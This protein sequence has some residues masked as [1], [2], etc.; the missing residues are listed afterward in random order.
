MQRLLT[1]A[2]RRTITDRMT[3]TG[4]AIR[5]VAALAIAAMLAVSLVNP[6]IAVQ[7]STNWLPVPVDIHDGESIR[8]RCGRTYVGTLDLR[9]RRDVSVTTVGDCGPALI[10]PALPV[11]GWR[12]APHD[13]QTWVADWRMA[14]ALLEM[15]GRFL[16]LA[17]HPNSVTHWLAGS[18]ESAGRLRAQLPSDDLAGA[19]LVWRAADWLIQ[20]RPIARVDELDAKHS[21]E[22]LLVL[23]AGDDEGFGLLPQTRFYV[24]GKRWMMDS[25]GEWVWED[26]QLWLRLAAGI[27][28]HGSVWAAPAAAGILANDSQRL[29]I[30][31]IAIRAAEVGINGAGSRDMQVTDT[32]ISNSIEAALIAGTRCD[33]RRLQVDGTVRHGVRANDDAR[34]V[35]ITDSRITNTGMLGMPKRSRGAIVF[36]L[37]VGQRVQRNQIS[38]ASFVGIRV[39]RHALVTDNLIERACQRLSDCGGI[40]TFDRDREPLHVRIERNRIRELGASPGNAYTTAASTSF[41]IYLDD[42]ANGVIVRHN[43]VSDNPSGMQIHNG[44]R[45]EVTSNRFERN[46]R[47]HLLFNE[48]AAYKALE[49]NRISGNQFTGASSMPAFRLWSRHGGAHLSRFADFDNN[50]YAPLPRM[51]AEVEGRGLLRPAQWR[52]WSGERVAGGSGTR[53]SPWPQFAGQREQE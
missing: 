19:T 3:R 38:D 2:M 39:F 14:P 20:A 35:S 28:P 45:N 25:P 7:P 16:P 32:R 34:D 31:G 6:V 15:N 30:A 37:A 53:P 47:E 27:T 10:T 18:S 12:R 9:G 36:E 17:H 52:Q 46:R 42:F 51:M 44:F 49:G 4:S 1:Q 11:S 26:G 43:H 29:R 33:L 22:R 24:E 48:T 50:S 41:G 40:Y 8:L 23:A 5:R 21:D 13:A